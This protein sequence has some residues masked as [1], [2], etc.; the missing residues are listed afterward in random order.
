M[1]PGEEVRYVSKLDTIIKKST[2]GISRADWRN[3]ILH[4]NNTS[5]A[6]IFQYIDDVY[7]YKAILKK[8]DIAQKK[9]SGFFSNNSLD[10]LIKALSTSLNL[11]IQKDTASHQ[12]I[13]NY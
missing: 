1:Q 4:F 3:G 2:N 9:I 7:G 5:I 12:L 13:V 10:G 11:S 8:P 6:E